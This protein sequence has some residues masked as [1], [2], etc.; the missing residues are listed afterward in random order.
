[1]IL[2]KKVFLGIVLLILS[3]ILIACSE[4]SGPGKYDTFAKCLTENSVVMYGTEWCSHCKDQKKEFG[5]SFRFA[6][7]VDCDGQKEACD[8]AGV[9][10]YPTWVI[11][12]KIYPGVK[13]LPVLAALSGCNLVEDILPEESQES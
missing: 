2:K 3:S 5:S 1:M 9:Q 12:G 13:G 11:D 8:R 6:T 4:D 7:F 10:G